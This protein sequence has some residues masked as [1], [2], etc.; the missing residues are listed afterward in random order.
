MWTPNGRGGSLLKG[1]LQELL[2]IAPPGGNLREGNVAFG[3]VLACF[4]ATVEDRIVDIESIRT[5]RPRREHKDSPQTTILKVGLPRGAGW[6][7]EP[8]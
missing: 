3:M 2:P 5:Q 6:T 7:S 1:R 8:N 4:Q